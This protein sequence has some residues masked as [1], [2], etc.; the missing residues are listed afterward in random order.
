MNKLAAVEPK[1]TAV[2]LLKPEPL[3]T[4]RFPPATGPEVGLI[5]VT[6]GGGIVDQENQALSSDNLVAQVK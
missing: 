3:M 5:V 4:T 2:A 6:V 1:V